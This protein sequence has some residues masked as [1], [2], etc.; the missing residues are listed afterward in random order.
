MK[1]REPA[2]LEEFSK[3]AVKK[4]RAELTKMKLPDIEL[5]PSEQI[6]IGIGKDSKYAPTILKTKD[7]D[8]V[9][10]W[11]GTPS[12]ISE[13]RRSKCIHPIKDWL[14]SGV[15]GETKATRANL[16]R[17]VEKLR[18]N[19]HQKILSLTRA[20]VYGD[21]TEISVYKPLLEH[22]WEEFHIPAWWFRTIYVPSGSVVTLSPGNAG[23]LWAYAIEIEEGGKVLCDGTMTF[24]VSRI[25]KV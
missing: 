13:A 15:V 12:N 9:K 20:Y 21:S 16:K 8:E 14:P 2:S 7:I 10:S 19:D 22:Y 6:T 17:T 11:I 5:K 4:Y 24:D 18:A 3:L 25:K 1:S 23:I